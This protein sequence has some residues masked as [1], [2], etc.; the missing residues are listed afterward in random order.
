MPLLSVAIIN[1]PTS[2]PVMVPIPP[3]KLVPPRI[4]AAMACPA[5]NPYL[6]VAVGGCSQPARALITLPRP[7]QTAHAV[8]EQQH[9]PQFL[10]LGS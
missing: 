9:Q 4:T 1:A 8:D 5:R 6:E 7:E 2:V 3:T 10:I